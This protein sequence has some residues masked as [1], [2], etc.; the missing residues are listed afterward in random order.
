[1]PDTTIKIQTQV[2]LKGLS[3]FKIG[4]NAS[5]LC[6]IE[7]KSEL[8]SA[9]SFAREHSLNI[10][11]LGGGSNIVFDDSEL[12]AFVAQMANKGKRY[13]KVGD[14]EVLV[15]AE[16]GEPWDEFVE[17]T[18]AH[19]FYGLEKL[20]LIPGTV[21]ATPVQN[22][23]AYGT[24][25]KDVI[26]SVEVF[27]TQSLALRT[28]TN[29][30]CNFEY[31]NSIFKSSEGKRFIVAAVTFRLK[32]KSIPN[33]SYKDLSNYFKDNPNPTLRDVRSAVMEIRK[34]KFPDLNIYGTAGSFFKNIICNE[35]D[36]VTLKNQYPELPVYRVDESKVKISTAFVLDK[37]CGLRGY[38][39]GDVGLFQ[40]QS[41]V[42]VN[43]GNATSKDVKEFVTHIKYLVK[44]KTGI[45]IEE[46][47]VLA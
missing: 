25:V 30:E 26:E 17:W 15:T 21:G 10:F 33:I 5:H 43:Y 13:E 14:E 20:S 32:L 44:E 37:V 31:R 46:E 38:R 47:V 11:V 40:N 8:L 41:L 36:I 19:D 7:D 4:G 22:I 3:T 45:E 16:A 23:G 35:S 34:G 28:L 9:I 29:K 39:E 2:P 24:E 42:V 27:D 12:K 18:V 1:M 6:V